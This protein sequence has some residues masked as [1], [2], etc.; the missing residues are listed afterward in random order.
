[1]YSS[2]GDLD[3]YSEP[4][5]GWHNAFS[6]TQINAIR[7]PTKCHLKSTSIFIRESTKYHNNADKILSNSSQSMVKHIIFVPHFFDTGV[8]DF[9][10]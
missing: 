4:V 7:M 3:D 10:H 9:S 5:Q 2:G 6:D 8:F 1:M